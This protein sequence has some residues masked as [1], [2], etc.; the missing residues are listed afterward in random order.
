M[1]YRG[2]DGEM[3]EYQIIE[4]HEHESVFQK[5]CPVLPVSLAIICAILNLVPGRLVYNFK[6]Y[7]L[8]KVKEVYDNKNNKKM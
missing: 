3:R 1:L 2:D 4:T 8:F 5:A 6:L 7:V